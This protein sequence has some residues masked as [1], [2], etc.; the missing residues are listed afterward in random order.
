M[1]AKVTVKINKYS[2]YFKSCTSSESRLQHL[3]FPGMVCVHLHSLLQRKAHYLHSELARCKSVPNKHSVTLTQLQ[4]TTFP[5]S[6]KL[7]QVASK[8]PLICSILISADYIKKKVTCCFSVHIGEEHNP[9]S[10]TKYVF[11]KYKILGFVTWKP[12]E[13]NMQACVEHDVG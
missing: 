3:I 13:L 8:R 10:A 2:H 7:E 12:G 5:T 11:A 1:C 4:Q 9:V 6:G